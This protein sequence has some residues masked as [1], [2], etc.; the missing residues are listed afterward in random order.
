MSDELWTRHPLRRKLELLRRTQNRAFSFRLA[1][2]CARIR[3][4]FPHG[5]GVWPIFTGLTA[6]AAR[7]VLPLILQSTASLHS[8]V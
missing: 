6:I 1:V 3:L 5:G 8:P 2:R 4:G 7:I